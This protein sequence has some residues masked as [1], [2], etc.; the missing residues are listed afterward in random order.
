[1]LEAIVGNREYVFAVGPIF[2]HLPLRAFPSAAGGEYHLRDWLVRVTPDGIEIWRWDE[3]RLE[4][5]FFVCI[6]KLKWIR[7]EAKSSQ[8]FLLAHRESPLLSR[9]QSE[10]RCT[11]MG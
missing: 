5:V 4:V 8:E 10:R 11:S 7:L 3:I 6:S 1:M 2:Q 9:H